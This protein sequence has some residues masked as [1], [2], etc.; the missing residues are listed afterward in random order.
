MRRGPRPP[1]EGILRPIRGRLAAGG[2]LVGV[3]TFAA[4]LAGRG[5]STDV[6]R[7]MAF[8]TLVAAELAY[9]LTVRGERSWLRAGRN[10]ALAGGIALSAGIL[11]AAL[12]WPSVRGLLDMAPLSGG[13]LAIALTLAVVPFALAESTKAARRRQE[14]RG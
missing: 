6:A 9:V 14:R 10:P 7:T 12:G 11:A 13:Q 3:V 1:D 5:T 4:F 2:V 8:T